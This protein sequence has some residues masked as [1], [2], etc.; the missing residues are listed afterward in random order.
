ME[1]KTPL[2]FYKDCYFN[3]RMTTLKNNAITSSKKR[4]EGI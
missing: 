2:K 3:F 4:G 1:K